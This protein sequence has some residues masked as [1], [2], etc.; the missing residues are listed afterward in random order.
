[1]DR[2]ATLNL[3]TGCVEPAGLR[4]CY[5]GMALTKQTQHWHKEGSR[6]T[7]RR[8]SPA[9]ISLHTPRKQAPPKQTPPWAPAGSVKQGHLTHPG[10][11]NFLFLSI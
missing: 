9:T 10:S 11:S 1:M 8:N 6:P 5:G 7:P 2:I 4:G 3:N